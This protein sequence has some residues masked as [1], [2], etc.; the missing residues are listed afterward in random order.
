MSILRRGDKGSDVVT[1]QTALTRAGYSPGTID[2]IFGS[3]TEAAVK[4]F[5]R[6]MGLTV[7]GIV[8]SKTWAA[9]R[10]T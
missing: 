5:Q 3:N 9:S 8:G 4:N 10:R 7:D 6:V 1:L 2:G